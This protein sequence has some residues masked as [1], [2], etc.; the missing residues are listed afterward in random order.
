M[1]YTC[2]H[3]RSHRRF[4]CSYMLC[5]SCSVWVIHVVF[6]H[7]GVKGENISFLK[8]SLST[9]RFNSFLTFESE[10]RTTS[11]IPLISK[12]DHYDLDVWHP[13][14]LH[15]LAHHNFWLCSNVDL[16]SFLSLTI[17]NKNNLDTQG[18]HLSPLPLWN[19]DVHWTTKCMK[20]WCP[21]FQTSECFPWCFVLISVLPK[22]HLQILVMNQR[23]N[24]VKNKLVLPFCNPILLWLVRYYQLLHPYFHYY[25]TS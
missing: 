9:P 18:F 23:L 25:N 2:P 20:L 12:G 21:W 17:S 16:V 3:R 19:M 5:A 4:G 6:L 7:T 14:K 1:W 11:S 24:N 15:I 10:P 22:T 8:L 13:L